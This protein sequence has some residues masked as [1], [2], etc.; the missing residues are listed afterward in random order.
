MKEYVQ[1]IVAKPGLNGEWFGD[2]DKKTRGRAGGDRAEDAKVFSG[3]DQHP[4]RPQR[5][6]MD[7]VKEH[8]QTIGVTEEDA[9]DRARWNKMFPRGNP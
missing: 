8:M 3:R 2:S 1:K 6:F 5:R 9:R 4:Q 7:V